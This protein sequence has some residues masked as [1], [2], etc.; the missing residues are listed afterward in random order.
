MITGVGTF[1]PAVVVVGTYCPAVVVVEH[2]GM[3][4]VG[5][6]AADEG[7]FVAE[8][9]VC[10]RCFVDGLF[11]IG[12]FGACGVPKRRLAFLTLRGG[13]TVTLAAFLEIIWITS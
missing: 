10:D 1:C 6:C 13:L 7:V 2:V 11:G 8:V 12:C 4:C 9:L 3:V 5:A